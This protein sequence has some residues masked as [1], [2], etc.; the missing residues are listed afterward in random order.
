MHELCDPLWSFDHYDGLHR[1]LWRPICDVRHSVHLD[2][3]PQKFG[4]ATDCRPNILGI[5]VILLS[6]DGTV[7]CVERMVKQSGNL[8]GLVL[9]HRS[10][11]GNHNRESSDNVHF[12]LT[13]LKRAPLRCL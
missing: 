4:G 12:D 6:M 9:R 1:T 3:S 11:R 2:V 13:S 5:V 10:E 7:D 8:K